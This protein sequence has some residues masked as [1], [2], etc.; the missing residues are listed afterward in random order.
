MSQH[1]HPASL[2]AQQ[3]GGQGCPSLPEV[4]WGQWYLTCVCIQKPGAEVDACPRDLE[5]F[6]LSIF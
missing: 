1:T 6:S 4:E 2:R 3:A 5:Y